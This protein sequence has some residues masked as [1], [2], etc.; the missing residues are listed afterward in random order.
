MWQAGFQ[1]TG[2]R[3]FQRL[4]QKIPIGWGHC[5][6]PGRGLLFL[7]KNCCCSMVLYIPA[8]GPPGLSPKPPTSDSPQ[9]TTYH[10]DLSSPDPKASGWG[11]QNLCLGPLEKKRETKGSFVSSK[12]HLSLAGKNKKQKQKKPNPKPWPFMPWC[13]VI[14]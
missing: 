1:E 12:F 5:F 4:C 11:T 9:A 6:S 8:P 2:L 14:R 13:Y 7:K 10:A 3:G